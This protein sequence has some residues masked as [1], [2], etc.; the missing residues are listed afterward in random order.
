LTERAKTPHTYGTTINTRYLITFGLQQINTKRR[1]ILKGCN[2]W[3][4]LKSY[5][6]CIAHEHAKIKSSKNNDYDEVL[7]TVVD[8]NRGALICNLFPFQNLKS[9]GK[10]LVT[11]CSEVYLL[12]DFM[13]TRPQ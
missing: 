2:K 12:F 6:Y 13:I 4:I 9:T 8:G 7:C 10:L 1:V 5:K 11:A 3:W